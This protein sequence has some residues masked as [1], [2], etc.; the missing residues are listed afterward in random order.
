MSAND[1]QVLL[2]KWRS[3]DDKAFGDLFE[4]HASHLY[5]LAYRLARR[6]EDARDL[7][8]NAALRAFSSASA[9]RNGTSFYGW[10]R[11]VV[12]NLF[13]DGQKFKRRAGRDLLDEN[14]DWSELEPAYAAEDCVSPRD[15][16]ERKQDLA[17]IEKA[18]SQLGP[19]YRSLVVLR[20]VEGLSYAE[21]AELEA[22]P[23]ETVRTRLRRAR[24]LLRDLLKGLR[25]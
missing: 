8:Q 5:N 7:L 13:L 11:S 18:L 1:D 16:L 10:M 2:E 17:E 20:E 19:L 3:G 14:A 12:T 23:I 15:E 6:E 25:S 22:I 21:I 24:T 9:C 4:R